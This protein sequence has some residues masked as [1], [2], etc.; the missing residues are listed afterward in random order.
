MKILLSSNIFKEVRRLRRA[1]FEEDER[2]KE[3]EFE[4]REEDLL[5]REKKD[6]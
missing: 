5:T 2:L 1:E 4:K 6:Y 3:I